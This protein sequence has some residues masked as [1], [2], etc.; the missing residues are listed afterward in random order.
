MGRLDDEGEWTGGV[1][2]TGYRV[3]CI[4]LW[5]KRPITP[6]RAT[7]LSP[8]SPFSSHVHLFS[9]YAYVCVRVRKRSHTL[10]ACI[11]PICMCMYN[12][13]TARL[14]FCADSSSLTSYIQLLLY[15]DYL[16]FARLLLSLRILI[17]IFICEN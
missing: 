4:T 6:T 16:I 11:T 17:F 15:I 9:F 5:A 8:I 7:R 12:V 2:T 1:P 14:I 13:H 3:S 10:Y